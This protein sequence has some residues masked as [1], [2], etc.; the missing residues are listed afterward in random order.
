MGE[1]DFKVGDYVT[2]SKTFR[3]GDEHGWAFYF[4]HG[5]T[6]EK[7][8]PPKPTEPTGLEAV[9]LDKNGD[10]YVRCDYTDFPWLDPVDGVERMWDDIEITEVLSNGYTE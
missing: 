9:V 4:D 7:V 3:V 8:D 6:F 2:V 1:H 10:K 5:F